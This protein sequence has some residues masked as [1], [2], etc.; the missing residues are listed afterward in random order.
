MQ[1]S[2]VFE[3]FEDK[4]GLRFSWNLIPNKKIELSKLSVPL[5][6][7]YQP[8]RSMDQPVLLNE[9]PI[10]CRGC[11]GILNPYCQPDLNTQSWT[12]CFCFMRNALPPQYH[13]QLPFSTNQD[14]VNVEYNLPIVSNVTPPIYIFVVDTC[15]DH[16]NI[17]SLTST[18]QNSISALPPDSIVGFISFGKNVNIHQLGNFETDTSYVFNGAKEYTVDQIEKHLN[19]L[20]SDLR[21]NKQNGNA[22]VTNGTGEFPGYQFLQPLSICEF[23]IN[24]IIETLVQDNFPI[25]KQ[26]RAER[27]TGS[28]INIAINLLQSYFNKTGAHIVVFSGGPCTFGPGSIVSTDLKDPLRSHSD[29]NKDNKMSRNFK[30][31]EKFYE[32]LSKTASLSGH[33]VDLFIGS[34]DQIGLS[35]MEVL[36]DKTGGVVVQSDDFTTAI[37]KQSFQRFINSQIE[38]GIN[39]TLELKVSKGL[40]I[41]GLLG[42]A[43][44]LNT[45]KNSSGS[46]VGGVGN[47]GNSNIGEIIGDTVIGEGNTNAW[48]L[49]SVNSHSTYAIYF[50]ITDNIG[51]ANSNNYVFFQFIT[52]YQ[53]CNGNRRLH[54]TTVTKPIVQQTNPQHGIIE[55]FDQEAA[56]VIIAREAI[57]KVTNDNSIDAIRWCD[58]VL[59]ELLT[60]YA[61]YRTNEVSSFK[62][63][64]FLQLFPQF[65]YHLRR[66]NF[67]QVF[68]SS[69]DESAF[70]R[71]VFNSE[72]TLNSLTMI[73]PSLTSFEIDAEPQV[74][75]LDSLSIKPTR[76]LLLDTFFHLLIYHGSQIAEWKRL[77]YQDMEEY[78]YLKEFFERPRL[79]AAEILVDRFPLPRFIDTE[80][81]GSQARFLYSKL[82]PTTSYKNNDIQS[83]LVGGGVGV[84][85]GA[86]VLTDDVSFQ[87]F[88]NYVASLVVKP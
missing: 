18:L 84:G 19:I 2:Q 16:E 37:F 44:S 79:E 22:G 17:E 45:K 7:L 39:A 11:Q 76:I 9:P 27:C 3:D 69:P 60:R 24:K 1:T 66:S 65:M 56:A 13:H 86:V 68:N 41:N 62:L 78:E 54:V 6:C 85:D 52:H 28:A 70:Y 47:G 43:I 67:I 82:N 46:G 80:E 25:P 42:H 33:T 26:H 55:Y 30:K 14:C 35:E 38:S 12:C 34:Y 64:F 83:A 71:H 10:V 77:G 21:N 53:H 58:K 29:L 31:N 4:T 87:D 73:Q 59:V 61:D 49:G 48:K 20:S 63:S 8:L 72:D 51:T 32:S 36:I 81:G 88:L 5:A 23:Q 40:K 57:Y 74:V 50:D 15:L 75:L